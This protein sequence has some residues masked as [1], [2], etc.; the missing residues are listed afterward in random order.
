MGIVYFC[1]KPSHATWHE[2]YFSIFFIAKFKA[3]F[4]LKLEKATLIISGPTDETYKK[5]KLSYSSPRYYPKF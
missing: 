1:L 2:S 5:H 3:M 4:I